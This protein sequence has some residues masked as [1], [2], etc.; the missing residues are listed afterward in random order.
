MTVVSTDRTVTPK[1]E[2]GAR[3]PRTIG[4][5]GLVVPVLIGLAV[6]VL[7]VFTV[8]R[9]T[10]AFLQADGVQQS[11]MSVQSVDLFFW[12]QNRFAAFV[13]LLA[14]P[15]A[16]PSTNLFVCL[17]INALSFHVLLLVLA[18]M[19]V[20]VLTTTRT[21]AATGIAFLVLAA[22]AHTVLMPGRVHIMAL[23]SQPY[24]MSW[25]LALGAFLLW[26]RR[27]WWAF[28]LAA[29]L[30]WAA[31]GLN[32]TT[33]LGAAF[34][35]VIE[36]V[37]RRQWWRWILFGAVW[38]VWFV[39]W[40]WLSARY[41]GRS[42]PAPEPSLPYFTFSLGQF[43]ANTT[44]SAKTILESFRGA[45]LVV[46]VVIAC[47]ALVALDADRRAALV[48]RFALG[49]VFVVAYWT[50]FTGNEYVAL[51]GYHFRYFYPVLMFVIVCVA[52]PLA[53][54]LA[55]APETL[56]L[57]GRW[58]DRLAS[59][60]SALR[61]I[62]AVV[63]GLATVV[64][65]AGPLRSPDTA[66]VLTETRATGRYAVDHG[67]RFISGYYWDMWPTLWEGLKSGR[68]A[69]FVTGLKSGGDPA[70][71]RDAFRE[72]LA[73]GGGYPRAM[74]V[75]QPVSE[76]TPFLDYWTAPGWVTTGETCPIP[77]DIEALGSPPPERSCRVLEYRGARS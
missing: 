76:C 66:P 58:A 65:V 38:A 49:T 7:S 40:Q 62:S 3:P 6:V 70:G 36:L 60:A 44:T 35:A 61:A 45:R 26:K 16:D 29:S 57:P 50:L 52:A 15:I 5:R 46:L 34:L 42:T 67:I 23:E 24:S 22:T 25:A 31:V 33:V 41:G 11:V 53:A 63:A 32:P 74:C 59:Q 47:L 2:S 43:A 20:R 9:Y 4:R 64:A 17:L 68:N 1:A 8:L 56:A 27:Q 77:P 14:S 18:W 72:E 55:G 69:V 75:N 37:R 21:A 28:P 71:Y 48:R 54:V 30:A 12:G 19:G 73:K 39:V 13:S 10:V 51:G